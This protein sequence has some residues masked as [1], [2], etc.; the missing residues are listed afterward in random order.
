MAQNISVFDFENASM[1]FSALFGPYELAAFRGK[2]WKFSINSQFGRRF[3]ES[4]PSLIKRDPFPLRQNPSKHS[5]DLDVCQWRL[6]ECMQS[7]QRRGRGAG[8][9]EG[10][11]HQRR[12]TIA[13]LPGGN[14]PRL[15]LGCACAVAS[16]GRNGDPRWRC[17][18]TTDP[19]V[20][21]SDPQEF[22]ELLWKKRGFERLK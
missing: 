16:L 5:N 6:P 15:V 22:V 1:L 13:P 14:G 19:E 11:R 3:R 2:D 7:H 8:E 21:F 18:V 4:V 9:E 12:V 17:F 10:F 20:R